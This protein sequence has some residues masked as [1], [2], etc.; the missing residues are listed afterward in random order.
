MEKKRVGIGRRDGISNFACDRVIERK[1]ERE[2][3]REREEKKRE[4]Q[5][6]EIKLCQSYSHLKFYCS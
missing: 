1:S 5:K 6:N 2:R 4:D 3:E